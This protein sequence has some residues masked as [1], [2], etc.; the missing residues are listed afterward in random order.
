MTI[1]KGSII[2]YTLSLWSVFNYGFQCGPFVHL[3]LPLSPKTMYFL[4]FVPILSIIIFLLCLSL[5][6]P[7]ATTPKITSVTQSKSL[8]VAQSPKTSKPS[9][10]KLTKSQRPNSLQSKPPKST[11]TAPHD[12]RQP[13]HTMQYPICN[14]QSPT[15]DPMCPNP[16]SLE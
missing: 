5:A 16:N 13:S 9:W 6:H 1:V 8:V 4:I 12:N 3:R 10:P 14:T 7:I 2:D 15:H 11:S